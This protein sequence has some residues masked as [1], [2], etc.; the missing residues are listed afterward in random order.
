MSHWTTGTNAMYATCLLRWRYSFGDSP[1]I[2]AQ[3]T[4]TAL[5]RRNA[6]LGVV[7]DGSCER[8]SHLP[9]TT[10]WRVRVV[11]LNVPSHLA[12]LENSSAFPAGRRSVSGLP[13][14]VGTDGSFQMECGGHSCNT[15]RRPDQGSN[16]EIQPGAVRAFFGRFRLTA[17]FGL[18][19]RPWVQCR[20]RETDGVTRHARTSCIAYGPS[21]VRYWTAVA[22]C[23]LGVDL[24]R[25]ESMERLDLV[26]KVPV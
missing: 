1:V 9:D 6:P 26:M 20:G 23:S 15:F 19:P 4:A 3:H 5:Q 24:C 10:F 17:D 22:H 7:G 2:A 12:S 14:A 18:L 25:S 16:H 8:G 21:K 11:H 13:A